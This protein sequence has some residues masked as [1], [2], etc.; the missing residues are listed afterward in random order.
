MDLVQEQVAEATADAL[1][2]HR[3]MQNFGVGLNR[4]EEC[5]DDIPEARRRLMPTATRCTSCQTDFE[6][7][8][9]RTV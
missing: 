7:N 4:C 9:R 5:G 6:T 8:S 1:R 2:D 3:R